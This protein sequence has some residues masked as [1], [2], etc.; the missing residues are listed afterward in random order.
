MN[1]HVFATTIR[2][3]A[4]PAAPSAQK[5]DSVAANLR[6]VPLVAVFI[7]TL[8]RLQPSFYV[9]LLAFGEVFRK[10]FG[11]LAPQH[12]AVPLGLLLPLSTLVVPHLGRRH[13]DR[14]DSG[15]AWRVAQFGIA[16][17]I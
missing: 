17:E 9:D 14:R 8:T 7:V 6:G 3:H 15:A 11:R 4:A 5:H 1:R 16:S 10:R 2:R 12:D 13:V